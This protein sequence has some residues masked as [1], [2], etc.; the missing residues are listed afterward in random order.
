MSDLTV[1]EKFK[2]AKLF[3]MSTGYVLNFTNRTFQEFILDCTGIDIYDDKYAYASGSKANRL[4]AFW[5]KEPN[6]IVGKLIS[7]LLEYWRTLKITNYQEITEEEQIL[8]NECCKIAE[9]LRQDSPVEHIDAIQPNIDDRDFSLLAKSI[10]ENI[11]KNE[12]EV[13]LDR[14]HTFV[15][16]YIRQLCKK[17]G[18]QYDKNKPLHSLFGEYVKF[19]KQNNMIESQMTERILKSS[20]SIL[21]AFNEVRNNQSFAHDNPILNYNESILIFN[22]ISSIIKFLNSIEMKFLE[23][24]E[25]NRIDTEW[26]N[27]SFK[28]N[29]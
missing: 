13:A 16:K 1:I 26:G 29:T 6:Y 15:V 11:Q 19:L 24:D 5:A 2:L 10:R 25:Q 18:I 9:R 8:F 14:L 28:D 17:H 12:P 4:R 20:I 27:F 23:E 22:N 7:A 3:E 21:E